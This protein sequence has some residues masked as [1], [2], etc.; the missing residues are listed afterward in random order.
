MDTA[1][2]DRARD[3]GVATFMPGFNALNGVP[4]TGNIFTLQTILRREWKFGGMVVSDYTAI[5]EMVQ[6]GYAADA[7]DAARK[8]LLAGVDMEMVSRLYNQNAAELVKTGQL[9]QQVIDEAVRR[10]LR[11]KFRLGLFDKPFTDETLEPKVILNGENLRAARE[12]AAR[13]FVLLKNENNVLPLSKT[14]SS[15]ALIGPLADDQKDMMGSWSGDGQATDAD[16]RIGGVEAGRQ[17]GA[18]HC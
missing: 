2:P 12:I 10:I 17:V 5:P 4:A 15:V 11:I 13:S 1:H 18:G 8:A 14:V 16:V 7:A 3:A 6:H 9:S